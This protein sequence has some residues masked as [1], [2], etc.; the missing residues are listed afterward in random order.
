MAAVDYFLKIDGIDGE[1]ADK[2]HAGEIDIESWSWGEAQTGSHSAGGG[3]GAGKVSMQDFHF[4]MKMNK[5]SPKLM[6]ACANG[7]HIPKAVLTMRK[8]GKEQQEY[9]KITLSDLLV[10]SYQTGGSGKGDIVPLEQ[11]ALNYAK[12]EFEYKEQKTDGSLGSPV[13]AGWDVKANKAT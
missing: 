7:Q 6:L 4:V 10:A 2:K 9:A 5:A 1:S 13:K 3:G 8:A 12:I 11:I